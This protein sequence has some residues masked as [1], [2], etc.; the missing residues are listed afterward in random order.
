MLVGPRDASNHAA[1]AFDRS[2][3]ELVASSGASQRI[4]FAGRVSAA[5]DYIRAADVFVLPSRREGMGNV[6]LE[7][8]ALGVPTVLTPYLGLP[9]EFGQPGEHYVLS[10]PDP[11][12]LAAHIAALL[13]DATRRTSI[14]QAGRLRV[15]RHMSMSDAIDA[16]ARIYRDLGRYQATMVDNPGME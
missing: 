10:A 15:E 13:S 5:D 8:M 2:V 6:V 3:D 12:S 9:A 4:H 14:G 1:A 16:Y 7:A 11:D